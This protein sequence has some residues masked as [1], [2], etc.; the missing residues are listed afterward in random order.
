VISEIERA[1]FTDWMQ[2]FSDRTW[3]HRPQPRGSRVPFQK[4]HSHVEPPSRDHRAARQAVT[5]S[6]AA[7]K[8]MI[9][10]VENNPY[11]VVANECSWVDLLAMGRH[12]K[13]RLASTVSIG[14]L[15]R[16]LLIESSCDVLTSRP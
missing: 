9:D 13:G 8:V 2:G 6:G 7:A 4:G 12:S 16:H 10:L 5:A 15:A 14:R 1:N 3:S 11:M